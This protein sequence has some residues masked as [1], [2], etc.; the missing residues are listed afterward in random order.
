MAQ[1]IETKSRIMPSSAAISKHS[2]KNNE[3]QNAEFMPRQNK[4]GYALPKAPYRRQN[5]VQASWRNV[6]GAKNAR[7]QGSLRCGALEARTA[8][9]GLR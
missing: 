4:I 1:K 9:Q 8:V 6:D 5:A 3:N 2:H 7:G